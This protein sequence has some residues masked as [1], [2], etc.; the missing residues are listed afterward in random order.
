MW[1]EIFKQVLP[2]LHSS[3]VLKVLKALMYATPVHDVGTLRN[4]IVV[5]CETMRNFP[6]IYQRIRLSMQRLSDSKWGDSGPVDR[7]IPSGAAMAHWI[8]LYQLGLQWPIAILTGSSTETGVAVQF[9]QFHEDPENVQDVELSR[10]T[11]TEDQHIPFA[12]PLELIDTNGEW[13]RI[14]LGS[15]LVDDL[16]IM[17]A[18]KYRAVSGVVW[19]NRA[20]A[21]SNTDT[22]RTGVLAVVDTGDSLLICLKC[23]QIVADLNV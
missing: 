22:Y 8:E 3:V 9:F 20:M 1:N 7:A 19:T 14:E 10:L 4:R 5:G 13:T 12:G 23:Q 15:P 18:V 21:R 16:P 2:E 17:N 11:H 6:G